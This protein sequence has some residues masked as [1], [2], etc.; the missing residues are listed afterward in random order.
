MKNS[1]KAAVLFL[2]MLMTGCTNSDPSSGT[3]AIDSDLNSQSIEIDESQQPDNSS[4]AANSDSLSVGGVAGGESVTSDSSTAAEP[5]DASTLKLK[6]FSGETLTLGDRN[7]EFPMVNTSK[8]K[9]KT[10]VGAVTHQNPQYD[11][12]LKEKLLA[13]D[14]DVDIYFFYPTSRIGRDIRNAHCYVPLTDES[15]ISARSKYFDWAADYSATDSGDIWCV[16]LSGGADVLYYVPEHLE[17]LGIKTEDMRTLD[18]FFASVNKI[19]DESDYKTF[20]ISGFFVQVMERMYNVNYS[21]S[22]YDNDTY[23]KLAE[24]IYS[25]WIHNYYDSFDAYAPKAALPNFTFP[26]SIYGIGETILW[27]DTAVTDHEMSNFDSPEKF[28]AMPYPAVVSADEKNTAS[29]IYAVINPNSTK[30]DAAQAYLGFIADHG[31]EYVNG[32]AHIFN[33]KSMYENDS[34]YGLPVFDDMYEINRDCVAWEMMA[35]YDNTFISNFEDYQRGVITLDE[36]VSRQ[37]LRAANAE[38]E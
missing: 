15:I 3:A 26:A 20:I 36:Y 8:V 13:G 38:I 4:E 25:S 33:D 35:A 12:E 18:G 22:D 19:A 17:Q 7:S 24:S 16:P 34:L 28:R 29:L 2:L 5:E 30:T 14:S 1:K 23:R 9:R 6:E 21:Y 37:E 27:K 11:E 31:L 32:S 10:G